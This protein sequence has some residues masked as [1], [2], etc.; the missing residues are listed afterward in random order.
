M[1]RALHCND[2]GLRLVRKEGE[3]EAFGACFDGRTS[4]YI[5]KVLL[6]GFQIWLPVWVAPGYSS[7][8]RVARA[9]PRPVSVWTARRTSSV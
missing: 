6:H 7:A 8:Q 4:V 3:H 1:L 5:K 2:D 9:R